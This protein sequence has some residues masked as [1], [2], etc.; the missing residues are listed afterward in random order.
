MHV[1][2]SV[3]NLGELAPRGVLQVALTAA[4]P[5]I[6]ANESGRRQLALWLTAKENP[7]TARVHAN[8]AWHWLFGAGLVR[9]TD[10]FGTTGEK[11]SH[12]ELL[13]FLASRLVEEGW[14]TKKLVRSIVLSHTYRLASQN[15]NFELRSP[16]SIDPENRLFAR[17]NRRRLDAECIRDTILSVSG[18]LDLKM[19]GPTF[20]AGMAADY[21]F[22]YT[23]CRRCVY[24]PGVSQCPAGDFRGIRFRRPECLHGHA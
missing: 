5:T 9:S 15:P 10:N 3:H 13:D 16:K 1:R 24:A 17:A 19:G 14:S 22:K 21:G 6:P 23:D 12:P 4:A 7:L 2:G 18:Q 20:K 8:R 11:P